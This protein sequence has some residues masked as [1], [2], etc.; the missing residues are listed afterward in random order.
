MKR[1]DLKGLAPTAGVTAAMGEELNGQ[2]YPAGPAAGI[3]SAVGDAFK[4][5]GC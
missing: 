3:T 2:T 1:A 4:V 5:S